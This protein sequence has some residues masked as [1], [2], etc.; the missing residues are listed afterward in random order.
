MSPL[1][2]QVPTY[3]PIDVN[4]KCFMG[5]LRARNFLLK[6]ASLTIDGL[7]CT[8]VGKYMMELLRKK[9]R[10]LKSVGVMV[11]DVLYDVSHTYYYYGIFSVL[12]HCFIWRNFL[13]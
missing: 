12:R 6:R 10:G 5:K 7:F 11:R 9:A 4:G 8:G 3:S 2:V 13:K 1:I